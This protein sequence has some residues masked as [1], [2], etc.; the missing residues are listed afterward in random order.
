MREEVKQLWL[1]VRARPLILGSSLSQFTR[2]KFACPSVLKCARYG[3]VFTLSVAHTGTAFACKKPLKKIY[4]LSA[5]PSL[6]KTTNWISTMSNLKLRVK[7]TISSQLLGQLCD[8]CGF[9]RARLCSVHTQFSG[10]SHRP[11]RP[12]FLF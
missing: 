3:V 8:G 9:P 4:L 12:S 7:S 10:P 6:M 1:R 5:L 2:E 11:A